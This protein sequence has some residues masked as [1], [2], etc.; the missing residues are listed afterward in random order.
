M[1]TMT[2]DTAFSETRQGRYTED[3]VI[4][5]PVAW[6]EVAKPY[7][8]SKVHGL[9]PFVPF[10]FQKTIMRG[11]A[12][13]DAYVIDKS[14]QIGASTAVVM[15]FAHQLLYR[16]K[17]TGI[18]QHCHFIANTEEVAIERL[19]KIAKIALGTAELSEVQR[20]N[21]DGIDPKVK[22]KEIRYYT[23]LAHNYIRAHPSNETAGRSFDGNAALMEEVAYMPYA[24]GVW[25]SMS[26]TLADM[27][28]APIFLV[29]T[30]NGDGDF[31]SE[32]VDNH[33]ELGLIHLPIDWR[34]H[35]DRLG[36]DKGEAWKKR[37]QQKFSGRIAEWEEEHELKRIKSGEQAIDVRIIDEFAADVNF[38]G[39]KP[40]DIHRYSK[41]VDIAG[42][43]RDSTVYTVIDLR[44]RPPQVVFQRSY[45]RQGTEE[46][47]ESIEVFDKRWSGSLF[48]DGTN[49]AAIPALV[50]AR[51]KI[52]IN[53]TA[54]H[55]AT[56]RTDLVE[57]LQWRNVPRDEMLS[58]L[59]AN[60]ESGLL[61]VHLDE[62]PKLR[63]A[64]KTAR[65]GVGEKK[66]G[67]NVDFLDSLM[68]ANLALTK[69][70]RK[71]YD[72][73]EKLVGGIPSSD[74]LKKLLGTKW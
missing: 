3:D 62:F 39:H 65:T 73:G 13:G 47:V 25:R 41:G 45:P 8:E 10:E 33:E 56:E 14:S 22:N 32:C 35:P 27:V 1:L 24:E 15:G 38:L 48:I 9:I 42:R 36:D 52:A 30:Y 31:F 23:T 2:T 70:I 29:S 46:K 64:L 5:D 4:L 34:A 7:I 71:G 21:L 37:S 53:F 6:C 18:P 54:G 49:D 68:L 44:T 12:A 57:G 40:I 59:I 11:V 28:H 19:L 55:R 61:I 69:R 51:K 67:K 26:R 63:E 58:W 50:K 60:L 72:D 74:K 16:A 66:R 43:G 17:A 20:K